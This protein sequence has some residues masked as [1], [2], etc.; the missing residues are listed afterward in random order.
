MNGDKHRLIKAAK[1]ALLVAEFVFI[2]LFMNEL[3]TY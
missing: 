2:A 3:D 1:P